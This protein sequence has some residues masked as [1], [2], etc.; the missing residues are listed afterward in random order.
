MPIKKSKAEKSFVE[1]L[2]SYLERPVDVNPEMLNVEIVWIEGDR[3]FGAKH[4]LEKHSISKQEVEEAIFEIPPYVEAKRSRAHPNR[5]LFWGETRSGRWIFIVCED[6]HVGRCRFLKP[7][8]AFTPSK[9]ESYWR[10]L[11]AKK[12]RK[13]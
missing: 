1:M 11:W 13:K 10:E 8:T 2:E 4:I 7:L 6:W 9:G 5:T 3:R 12:K